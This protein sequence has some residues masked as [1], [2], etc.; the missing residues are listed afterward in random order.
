MKPEQKSV[1]APLPDPDII[2]LATAFVLNLEADFLTSLT[3]KAELPNLCGCHQCQLQVDSSID[4][5]WE[6]LHRLDPCGKQDEEELILKGETKLSKR[7]KRKTKN[8][9]NDDWR[10]EGWVNE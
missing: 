5:V 4:N 3:K 8:W 7:K 10:D 2:N 9:Q 1:L 6:E